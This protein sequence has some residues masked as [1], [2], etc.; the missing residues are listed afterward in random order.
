MTSHIGTIKYAVIPVAGLGTR[1]VQH[2]RG[3][4]GAFLRAG[5]H[6]QYRQG[7]DRILQP[8]EHHA[9]ELHHRDAVTPDQRRRCAL[10]LREDRNTHSLVYDR[11]V[12]GHLR[13]AMGQLQAAGQ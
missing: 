9:A 12:P 8:A 5:Y 11:R 3:H 13:H 4:P 2:R 6:R 1:L 10:H 7:A